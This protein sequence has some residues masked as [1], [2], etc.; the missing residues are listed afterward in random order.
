MDMYAA[1][2]RSTEHFA[3][4][5]DVVRDDQWQLPTPNPGWTVRDLV[6]HV[7]GGN[8]RY[9]VLLSGAPT[10]EVE[11]LRH[12]EH[13]GEDPISAFTETAAELTDAFHTPG[14]LE[15]TVHHR[16]SD[17]S[18]AELLVMRVIEHTL[19]GWD[20]ARA[21]GADDRLD[22]DIAA[23]LLAAFDADPSM[24]GRTSF[25]PVQPVAGLDP[26]H[27]LLAITGRSYP[28]RH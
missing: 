24:L 2:D 20:L 22:P 15:M 16:L 4:L 26:E 11:A 18:G 13:L 19:H 3:K 23:T 7:V 14:A 21:I 1:L 25:P 6:N 17:R 28:T 12:L 27:R 5:L 9:V 8:R 10:A